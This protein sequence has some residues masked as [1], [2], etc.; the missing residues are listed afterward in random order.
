[1]EAAAAVE[2][3]LHPA[4]PQEVHHRLAVLREAHH[5]HRVVDQAAHLVLL[6]V[7][8]VVLP[9]RVL[10]KLTTI[11]SSTAHKQRTNVGDFLV[12]H[13]VDTEAELVHQEDTEAVHTTVAARVLHTLL[14]EDHH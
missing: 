10:G 3:A 13:Q 4:A 1:M 6:V 12:Q 7:L 2:E 5:H 9:V 14:A 11:L 8:L